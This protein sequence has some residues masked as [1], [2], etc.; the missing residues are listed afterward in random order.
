MNVEAMPETPPGLE[1]VDEWLLSRLSATE[2][3]AREAYDGYDIQSA[4]QSL[5]RFFWGDLCDW[6]IEVAKPRLNH[7]STRATPQWVL[8]T[9]FDAFLRMLH[10]VMPFLTEELYSHLPLAGKSPFLMSAPWPELPVEFARPE[11][12][13]GI[14]RVFEATRSFRALRA[15]LDLPAMRPISVAYFEGDMGGADSVFASQAWVTELRHGRPEGERFVSTSAA[16]I[17]MHLPISGL[18]DVDRLLASVGRDLAKKE[19]ELTKLEAQLA[20]PQFVERAKPEA[21]EKLQVN[22]AEAQAAIRSL[23]ERQALLA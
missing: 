14:E 4:C 3:A 5:Y 21:V 10:P 2:R 16:G 22:V 18:V 20:N 17:D 15:G 23:R 9:A 13:A 19:A 1:R 8:L 6:Y 7:P 11:A 12:E